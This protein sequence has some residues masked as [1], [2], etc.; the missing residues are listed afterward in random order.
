MLADIETNRPRNV[1]VKRAA[2]IL[3]G[4]WGTSKAYAIG[5]A[6][7]FAGYSS[8][9][10]IAPMCALTLLVGINYLFICKHHPDGGGVYAS[11]R[12]RSEV[13]SI[14]GAFLLIADYIVTAALSA[15]SA[16]QY[17]GV[18][19][20]EKF[21]ALA[22]GVIGALNWF[23]PK[24]TGNLAF[25]V[26]IPTA[27]VVVLLGLFSLPYLGHVH[28]EPLHGGFLENWGRFV[29]IV[30]A[31][32][33]VEAVANST[34]LMKLNPGSPSDKPSITKTSTPALLWVMAEV[35]FFTA[36]L[37]LAMHAL[38]G[39]QVT[40][41][42]DN[43]PTINLK[44]PGV[45]APDASGVRD[46]MLRYMGEHFVGWTLGP[47]A[48]HIMGILVSIVFGVLLLSAVNTAI[49]AL[50]STEYLMARDKELP[51]AFRRLNGFGVPT[52]GLVLSSV[53]PLA[54]VL[55]VSDLSG[56]AELYAVGVVGAMAT[57]LG[58]N[59]TDF[60]LALKRWERGLMFLT[61]L[62]MVVIEF[63]LLADKP[64]A[65]VFVITILAI[66]LIL[67][68]LAREEAQ[69][70]AFALVLGMVVALFIMKDFSAAIL[71]VTVMAFGLIFRGLL[72][73]RKQRRTAA[74]S[75]LVAAEAGVVAAAPKLEEPVFP[76]ANLDMVVNAPM[77]CAVRGK[78]KTLDF[79]LEEARESKRP[80]YL[81][82]VREQP[83]MTSE[84][85]KRKWRDDDEAREIFNYAR[86]KADGVTIL[87]GYAVS[88]SPADTIVDFAATIGAS[89]L[90]L[91]APQRSGLVNLLRGNIIRQ[92][93]SGLP[94]NIHLLVYA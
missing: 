2:A 65:R 91:G 40:H 76:E 28:L 85:R 6:F 71:S 63:S 73:E 22:I 26:S 86:S 79:A 37:G 3:Y 14:V 11:V 88:D 49:G 56:L 7:A 5:L 43:D 84:D 74:A 50:V 8:F 12:H 94:E 82:F 68:A 29:G 59:S 41:H 80:L 51:A 31:L 62:I 1:D 38:P 34:G 69:R 35:V 4:D 44:H 58:A 30:L 64:A 25:V 67:R 61:F 70:G 9:W 52:W 72:V 87:P 20:P 92:V 60:K 77:L 27:I 21:A 55:V 15:L 18:P 78:G 93:S 57:N 75:A 42:A 54:L 36:L 90:V 47:T 32:S 23:G 81:L 48:G 39:L 53:V 33:G 16:F 17:L 24:H 46:Y 45:D 83:V 19:H 66:G 13:I 10:L 89:R